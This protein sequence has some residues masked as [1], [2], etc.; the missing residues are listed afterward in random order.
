MALLFLL[1]ITNTGDIF[2]NDSHKFHSENLKTIANSAVNVDIST[3][4]ERPKRKAAL[5]AQ[6]K[7]LISNLIIE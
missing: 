7:F 5:E 3:K 1:T 2:S 6:K 4:V